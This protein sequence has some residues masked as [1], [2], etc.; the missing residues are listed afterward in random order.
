MFN[1]ALPHLANAASERI[2][3]PVHYND[4]E[5]P[6]CPGVKFSEDVTYGL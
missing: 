4:K 1:T 3:Q 5:P 2:T 6:Q